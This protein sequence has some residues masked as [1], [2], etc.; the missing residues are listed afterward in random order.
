M[1][2]G[3]RSSPP[4][5]AGSGGSVNSTPGSLPKAGAPLHNTGC[6]NCEGRIVNTDLEDLLRSG[7]ERFTHDVPVPEAW[8]AGPHRCTARRIADPCRRWGGHR[9][10]SPRPRVFAVNR[11]HESRMAAPST[12]H[13]GGLCAHTAG[14]IARARQQASGCARDH[15]QRHPGSRPRAWAYGQPGAGWRSSPDE[16]RSRQDQRRLH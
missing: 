4:P 10:G 2:G 12:R 1:F 13:D 6:Q 3:T 14:L 11:W 8:P 5:R 9:A 15:G 16:L 7:M